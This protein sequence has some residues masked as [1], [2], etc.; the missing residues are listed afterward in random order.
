MLISVVKVLHVHAVDYS[1]LITMYVCIQAIK[2][3]TAIC[4]LILV[5][6]FNRQKEHYNRILPKKPGYHTCLWYG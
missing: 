2:F 1:H 6:Y 4:I 3:I 5:T